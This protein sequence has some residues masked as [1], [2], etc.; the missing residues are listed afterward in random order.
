MR[1][2]LSSRIQRENASQS[3][4]VAAAPVNSPVNAAGFLSETGEQPHALRDLESVAAKL[5]ELVELIRCMA[6]KPLATAARAPDLQKRQTSDVVPQ[7]IV[8][9]SAAAIK[10]MAP[11]ARPVEARQVRSFETPASPTRQAMKL[12]DEPN[13]NALMDRLLGEPPV[14]AAASAPLA[15][16]G[17]RVIDAP[18]RPPLPGFST[19]RQERLMSMARFA[20]PSV[21]SHT[22][23]T[24]IDHVTHDAPAAVRA[25]PE[26]R[27]FVPTARAHDL[28]PTPTALFAEIPLA[29]PKAEMSSIGRETRAGHG[30]TLERNLKDIVAHF[31]QHSQAHVREA[32]T[33]T[34]QT[35]APVCVQELA[36][37]Y[38][39]EQPE[40]GV[41]PASSRAILDDLVKSL[42]IV[43][44]RESNKVNENSVRNLPYAAPTI[45]PAIVT[46]PIVTPVSKFDANRNAH[47]SNSQSLM[48]SVR[49]LTLE[50][51]HSPVTASPFTR[52]NV[53]TDLPAPPALA[54]PVT[55]PGAYRPSLSSPPEPPTTPRFASAKRVVAASW[56]QRRTREHGMKVAGAV[57]L[58]GCGW[59][60]TASKSNDLRPL[61]E[62]VQDMRGR[63]AGMDTLASRDDVAVMRKS[64]GDV[65]SGLTD[66]T[67]STRAAMAEVSARIDQLERA[68]GATASIPD[69]GAT[70]LKAADRRNVA[71]AP[72]SG[73]SS[74]PIN[75]GFNL[76]TP[77]YL[78]SA[79]PMTG[80]AGNLQPATAKAPAQRT[81]ARQINYVVREVYDGA[82]VVENGNGRRKVVVGD[83]L[84]GAGKV[85]SI[86]LRDRQWV[87]V[88][89]QGVI[90]SSVN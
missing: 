28:Q 63:L 38:R 57:A 25:R 71:A 2:P 35:S 88:T 55:R 54:T 33:D 70:P 4:P 27:A 58:L 12:A 68:A 19:K 86:E 43:Q 30:E 26:S 13:F 39:P 5:S 23:R 61:T 46:K 80:A 76:Q 74:A 50:K 18:E 79:P 7:E 84:P 44:V 65:K 42:G 52:E 17:N 89:T 78:G 1:M 37:E 67:T 75:Q 87:V 51:A 34:C 53:A 82:A 48:E 49:K 24:E 66:V 85:R 16:P 60:I 69:K 73:F 11:L 56:L 90:N 45:A 81:G 59:L 15:Q 10:P 72:A 8:Q 36:E 22:S 47:P 14:K 83:T 64:L 3:L 29:T 20:Q 40:Q 32:E 9:G 21:D 6:D 41:P 77:L 31:V 62:M